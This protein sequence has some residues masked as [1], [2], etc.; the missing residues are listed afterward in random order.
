MPTEMRR[1]LTERE[2]LMEARATALAEA[3]IAEGAPWL[4]KLGPAPDDLRQRSAWTQEVRTVA[5]YRDL[6]Q[7]DCETPVGAG[8]VTDRQRMDAA[9]A[10]RAVRRAADLA[11]EG[12]VRVDGASAPPRITLG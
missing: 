6:W 1:A 7:V 4:R 9:R 10:S 3:A 8:G 5:A 2:D 11:A 12:S